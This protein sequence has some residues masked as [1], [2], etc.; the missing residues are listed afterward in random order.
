MN[1]DQPV[2]KLAPYQRTTGYPREPAVIPW[3]VHMRAYEV[4]RAI[5]GEQPALI[6]LEGRGCRGGFGTGELF[7]FLYARS[8]PPEEWQRRFDEALKGM[9]E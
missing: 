8:F 1:P 7:A 2:A 9:K 3:A 5:C 4:Y 6:D